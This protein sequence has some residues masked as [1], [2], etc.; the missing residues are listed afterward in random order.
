VIDRELGDLRHDH[1]G[2]KPLV[3]YLRYDVDLAA[4]SVKSLMPRIKDEQIQGLNEMDA[5]ENMDALHTLGD[6]LGARDVKAADF[7]AGF[8]LA[9]V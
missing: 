4:D 5:P 6:K 3:S 9:R 1:V 2:G 7:A 8:D